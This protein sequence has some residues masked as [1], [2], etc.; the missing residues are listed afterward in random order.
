MTKNELKN[1]VL[2]YRGILNTATDKLDDREVSE[3]AKL[4]PTMKYTGELIKYHTRINWNGK[5]KRASVDIWDREENNPD[6]APNLWADISY[7]DGV[8]IIPDVITTELQ[9]SE[10]E[11]GWWGDDLYKSKVNGN[12]YTPDQYAPNWELQEK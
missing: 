11:L 5:V 1:R 3:V 7:R 8:R 9:F 6:N 4:L 12:V 10:N 2:I